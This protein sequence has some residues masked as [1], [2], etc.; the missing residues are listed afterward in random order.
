LNSNIKLSSP[1]IISIAKYK[2]NKSGQR[3]I[4]QIF[5]KTTETL[6][7]ASII[8]KILNNFE[9]LKPIPHS[10]GEA[11]VFF[12]ENN[13]TEQ[14]C[15][16]IR[17]SAKGRNADIFPPYNTIITAKKQCYPENCNNQRCN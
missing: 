1:E 7:C 17:L 14:Q 12:I 2:I 10:A 3:S 16:N 11:L 13:S 15:I 5:N 6:N 9:T 4:V 8:K